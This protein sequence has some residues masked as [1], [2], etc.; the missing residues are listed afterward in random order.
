MHQL[1]GHDASFL[2]SDT[3]HANANI[4][5]VQIYDPST[6]QGGKVRFKSILAHIQSRLHRAPVFRQRLQRVPLELDYPYWI[7]DEHFDL[8]HHVRHIALPHPGDWRQFC[9]QASRI[10]ARA[11]DLNRPLWEIYVIEGLDSL[12]ELPVGSFALLIKVHHAAVDVASRNE[13]IEVLHD[14]TRRPPKAAPPEPWFPEAAP[15]AL[16]LMCA[17]ATHTALSP[18]RWLAPLV[19]WLPA[20]VAF[21]ND[22]LRPEHVAST[23][24]NSVVSP[25]RVFDTRRFKQAEFERIS[26]LVPG[27]RV[28]DAVLAVCAGG[29]RSYLEA[30][31]ELPASDLSAW[32]SLGRD[33]A[34]GEEGDASPVPVPAPVPVPLRIQLGTRLADP[35]ERLVWIQ[36]QFASPEPHRRAQALG[37]FSELATHAPAAGV[38]LAA[39][40]FGALPFQRGAAQPLVSCTVT[41][42]PALPKSLYLG[43]AKMT[44]FS[45]ILPIADGMG[46]AFAVTRYEDL[47]VIS[48]TSCRE[49]IPDPLAFTQCLRDSFQAYL[50]LADAQVDALGGAQADAQADVAVQVTASTAG[51]RSPKPRSARKAATAPRAEP[52]GRRRSTA[53]PR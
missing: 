18:L 38:A 47:L 22:V 52:A 9:I 23:R 4:T 34:A 14:F 2:Y 33:P 50:A 42:L 21:A 6:A 48:P 12:A 39:K 49:L 46:L 8:E 36:Q 53:P 43:G 16:S 35:V 51:K 1:T 26:R 29:L 20:T 28:M 37:K 19:A 3:L 5:F 31:G 10:H 15:S 45:A 25:H 7:A 30:H 27:A 32:V 40:W 13:I 44:Y 24:F 41:E 17:A 11:L